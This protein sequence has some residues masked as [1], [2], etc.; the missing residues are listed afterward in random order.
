MPPHP[1]LPDQDTHAPDP[2]LADV[3]YASLYPR[4]PLT[5][6]R[7]V[8]LLITTLSVVAVAVAPIALVGW[9]VGIGQPEY[10]V[11][12]CLNPQAP[13]APAGS[14]TVVGI[15]CKEPHTWQVFAN[16]PGLRDAGREIDLPRA[17][18]ACEAR[19]PDFLGPGPDATRYRSLVFASNP[20]HAELSSDD[21]VCLLY[22][23]GQRGDGDHFAPPASPMVGSARNAAR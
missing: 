23:P 13:G 5:A 11:G 1:D 16:V 3:T 22:I 10:R 7:V 20:R 4:K 6:R 17:V 18:P 21:V 2:E 14:K 8:G 9:V 19:L 15:D 12:E